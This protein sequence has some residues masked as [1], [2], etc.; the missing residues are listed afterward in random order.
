MILSLLMSAIVKKIHMYLGL[1]NFSILLAFGLAGLLIT[2]EGDPEKRERPQPKVEYR[3]FKAPGTLDDKQVADAVWSELRPPLTQPLPKFALRRDG[4]NHLICDFYSVNGMTRVV[5]LEKEGRLRLEK[6]RNTMAH[7]L[8]GLH[9]AT[10]NARA[11][12]VPLRMWTWYVEFSIWSLIAMAVSGVWLWLASR[13][14]CRLAQWSF[15][16]GSGLFLLLYVWTR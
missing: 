15:A 8:A 1:L 4:E 7:Y 5:V 14:R 13:P 11:R 10:P 12:D 3:D 2:V 16:L 9:S 6:R